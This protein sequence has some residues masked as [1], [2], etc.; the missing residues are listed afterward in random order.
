M[1]ARTGFLHV[2]QWGMQS[3]LRSLIVV[4]ITKLGNGTE[5]TR[6]PSML[7]RYHGAQFA[8]NY[9]SSGFHGKCEFSHFFREDTC[10]FLFERKHIKLYG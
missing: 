9:T 1:N 3:C 7:L 10:I 8:S 6:E 5:G 4:L 2:R